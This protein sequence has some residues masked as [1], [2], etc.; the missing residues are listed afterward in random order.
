METKQSKQQHTGHVFHICHSHLHPFLRM[1]KCTRWE[2]LT[3]TMTF[4]GEL[5][6]HLGAPSEFRLLNGSDPIIVGLGDDNGKSLS[7]LKE[8]MSDSPAG[9]TPL[10]NHINAVVESIQSIA[11]VLRANNQKVTVMIATDGESSDGNVADALRPLTNVSIPHKST[12]SNCL[13][14]CRIMPCIIIQMPVLVILRLCTSEK[15]V[16]EYWNNIDQQLELDIDVLDDQVG[17]AKQ[18]KEHNPWLTY[19]EPL[20]RLREFGASMKEMDIIDESTVS[21]EQMRVLCSYL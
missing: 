12:I 5:S 4:L 1:V 15:E 18:V 17:D 16:V 9:P 19:G 10:C 11:D 8:V 20:H 21:S 3:G 7:F 14:I 6:E 13:L 2:E